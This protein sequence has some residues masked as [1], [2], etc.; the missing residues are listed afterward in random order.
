[1]YFW[2]FVYVFAFDLRYQFIRLHVLM[3]H[4]VTCAED[5]FID[6]NPHTLCP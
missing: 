5:V 3:D 4:H 6:M 1:M 2:M